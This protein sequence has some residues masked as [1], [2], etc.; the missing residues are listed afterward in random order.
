MKFLTQLLPVLVAGVINPVAAHSVPFER[1][2]VNDTVLLI[3]DHQVGLFD[4]ARDFEPG[5]FYR[6]MIT[7]AAIGKLFDIP[8]IMTTSDETGPNGP[9]PAEILE[10]HPNTTLI[11]RPGEID[12]WDN[13]D[14]KAAVRAT[15]RKQIV[16]AGIATDVCTTFL[17]L[18]LRAAGYSVWA[19][20]EASG[21]TST[22]I[23]EASNSRMQAAGVQLVGVFS[24]VGDLFRD[25]RNPSPNAA[26]FRAWLDKYAPE[27]G[28]SGRLFNAAKGK[29]A[30]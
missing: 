20:V 27:Y 12:A 21:T 14:F 19:N 2:N 23:R 1:L 15:G 25:W 13:P 8:V 26:Q 9:L 17:A 5:L 30:N 24:I 18:S 6:N 11:Q 29:S 16:L 22:L 3:V 4:L 7:H 28:M 10:M